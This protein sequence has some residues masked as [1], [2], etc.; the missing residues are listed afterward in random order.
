MSSKTLKGLAIAV[1]LL[2]LAPALYAQTTRGS[3]EGT[4][5]TDDGSALPGVTV[6][7]ASPDLPGSSRIDVTEADGGFRIPNLPPADYTVTFQLEGFAALTQQD[8]HVAINTMTPMRVTMTG[9]FGE[10]VVVSGEAAIVNTYSAESGVN[11]DETLF[12]NL[13]TG[14]DYTSVAQV[15]PGA[16]TDASGTTFYGSTGAENA[17]YI[18]GINTTGVELGQQG[19]LLNFEF[20]QEVQVKTAGYNAEYGRTTGGI[21]NVITKSGGN[22]FTGD[23]FGYYDDDSL[24]ANLSGEAEEG[25]VSGSLKTTGVTRSDLG[26]DLGGYVVQDRLWFFAAYDRVD[27]EDTLES[28]ENFSIFV[29]G[30]PTLGQEFTDTTTRDLFAG[31]LTFQASPGHSFY[32][33]AFGDPSTRE[34]ALGS[35]AAPPTHTIQTLDTGSTDYIVN[36]DGVLSDSV[37]LN[38]RISQH[39]EETE[40]GGAGRNLNGLLDNTDPLGDGTITWGWAG[41]PSPSG[42]GFFQDQSFGR[43][44]YRGDLSYFLDDFGGDHE[45]KVGVE[46]EEVSVEN[47]NFE[48]GGSRI[49]R[50]NCS[51]PSRCPGGQP[52]Y[53]RHRYF[54]N[55]DDIDPY[56]VSPSDINNPL[57]VD[58]KAENLAYFLQD[59]W[60]PL[61]NL[62]LD[63]GVR[64]DEQKLF[65]ADGEVQ[66]KLDDAIAPR[67]GVIWD[68]T[69]SGR[70]KVYGHYGEFY[71]TIPMDIVIRSYG[72][73]ISVFAYNFSDDPNAFSNDPTARIPSV[74]GGGFS[75]VDPDTESQH[76][77]ELVIGGEYEVI[78]NLAVGVKYIARDLQNVM[79]DAL[80]ADGHYFIGNPGRGLMTGTYDIGY[81]FGYNSTLHQLGIPSRE[82][83]GVELTVTKRPTRNFQF[84]AS[85]LW[86]ELQGDYDGLF[87]ASTGQLDP[88]LNSAFDY[89]DFSVNNQGYLSNDRRWQAKF[90]GV[91]HFE[92]GLDAGLSAYYRTGLPVTAMGYS[93][94]YQN[95]EYYLSERGA[96]GRTPDTY[97]ADLHLGYPIQLANDWEVT[98]L[99]DIFNILDQQKA[100]QLSNRYTP[101]SED[102][103][104]IDW[105]TGEI[106][107]IRP[108]DAANPPT[109][110]AFNTPTAWQDPTSV[111][112]GLRLSF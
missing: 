52:Y 94:A 23:V 46:F 91:Y 8:V 26:A 16:Q 74:L 40:T 102:Y 79:E 28:I 17:Y 57:T 48:S 66:Q 1:A 78:P 101:G 2:M 106:L 41:S 77:E 30:G 70:A 83:E 105:F 51:P 92:F 88:N 98:L 22:E 31:K 12:R 4:V 33:S 103:Q 50:F 37:L 35:L 65:N 99:L 5:T 104:P 7:V 75:N 55:S 80:S 25:A 84:L 20:I 81:A 107:T 9:A 29:P 100:T 67:L 53:Y 32:A 39:N 76:I 86:S 36:Y 47:Q 89:F 6:T 97:E 19:K 44:Q 82:F 87:Q 90:D 62:T 73:E 112:L 109:N 59:T 111:R 3:I 49:Y 96:F 10:E 42:I 85:L 45:L 93:E 11:V 68:P 21:I 58:T 34:G 63:L 56:N 60:R 18:D 13:P 54:V 14:R 71:E 38:A 61:S 43:D 72:G 108:G 15:T 24:R 95:W 110:A 69:N 27:N 64:Y